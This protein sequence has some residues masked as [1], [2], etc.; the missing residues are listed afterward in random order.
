VVRIVTTVAIVTIAAGKFTKAAPDFP[1]QAP[2]RATYASKDVGKAG[3]AA[4]SSSCPRRV[5]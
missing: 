5:P 2:E 1:A 4:V 3:G